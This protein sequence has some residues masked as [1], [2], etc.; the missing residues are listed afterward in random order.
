VRVEH[1]QEGESEDEAVLFN[2][3]DCV[4]IE[5]DVSIDLRIAEDD[6]KDLQVSLVFKEL[7]CFLLAFVLIMGISLKFQMTA[8]TFLKTVVV[9]LKF[10][11]ESSDPGSAFNTYV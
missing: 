7:V 11:D 4:M 9:E 6:V 3:L 5:K 8:Y 1:Q 2:I 10:T